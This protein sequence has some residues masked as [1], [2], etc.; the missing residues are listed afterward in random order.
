MTK[1]TRKMPENCPI[2]FD[3][4]N[5]S[6]PL[7]CQEFLE[8]H[9]LCY[10]EGAFFTPKGRMQDETPLKEA[11]FR[12]INPY[13][14]SGIANKI[15][16]IIELLK[17][18]AYRA[19]FPPE[20]DR[21]HVQNGT[22][23]LDGTMDNVSCYVVRSRLPIA[24]NPNAPEPAQWKAFLEE[25]LEPEDILTL[26][27]FV[28]YSLIPTTKAQRMMIIKGSGGEGKSQI[29]AVLKKLFGINAKDG[30]VGKVSENQFAR[31]DLEHIHLMID[32]DMRMEALKQTNYVKSLV[33]ARGKM[34][35][36]MKGR[37]SYQ[38]YMFA[39]L[40]AFSNGDLQSLYDRS[41]GFYRRQLILTTKPKNPNRV[42]DPDLAD[43]LCS[44]L[45]GIFLWAFK[46]LQRL[47]ANN[48]RFTESEHAR[49]N[50]EALKQ[51]GNN[52]LMFLESE[53]YIQFDPA[54]DATSKEVYAV[55]LVWCEDNGFPPL[56]TR[57]VIEYLSANAAILGLEYTNNIRSAD[58]RRVRGFKGLHM[59]IDTNSVNKNGMQRVFPSDIPF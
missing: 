32:D 25:L 17:I 35:L 24:Y 46:G 23:F 9:L 3:G 45:E 42:D 38:G 11:I 21:I 40:L 43:K 51:D 1:M 20:E 54:C 2:W 39:R 56:K 28:G 41:D 50:R 7:Y 52:L 33:T 5:L 13:L 53:D 6:E 57:T 14:K 47:I 22:L 10:S 8:N 31:A 19:D 30:S 4:S 48:Y 58:G 59:M 29:G 26:Q 12:E 16:N 15:R 49:R 34:D 36:E 55:Y 37:Q 18:V 27:E 44:E